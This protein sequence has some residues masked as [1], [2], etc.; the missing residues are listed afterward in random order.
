MSQG[1]YIQDSPPNV[2]GFDRKYSEPGWPGNRADLFGEAALTGCMCETNTSG[3][4]WMP[5][6]KQIPHHFESFSRTVVKRSGLFSRIV[7]IRGHE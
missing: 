1:G 6:G 2:I 3:D 4:G 7:P 5:S